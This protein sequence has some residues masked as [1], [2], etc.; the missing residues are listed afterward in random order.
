MENIALGSRIVLGLI[1]FVFGLNGFLG[2]IPTPKVPD[3]AGLFLGGLAN[4]PYFFPVLKTVEILGGLALLVGRFMPLTLVILAPI[5]L[6]IFLFHVFLAPA[7]LAMALIMNTTHLFLAYH[8]RE[9][10]K[11]LLKP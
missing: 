9:S 2:F 10:Y 4:A 7:G 6:Q 11:A 5:N 3:T 1:F 8:H